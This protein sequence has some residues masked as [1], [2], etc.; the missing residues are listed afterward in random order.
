MSKDGYTITRKLTN[1]DDGNLFNVCHELEGN[2]QVLA[3]L[4]EEAWLLVAP[5]Q[6]SELAVT[7][8]AYT[9]CWCT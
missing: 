9:S 6:G 7:S 8:A 3:L 2:G 5:A 4:N 1:V